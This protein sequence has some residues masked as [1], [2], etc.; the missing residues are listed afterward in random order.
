MKR[1]TGDLNN[2]MFEMSGKGNI[3]NGKMREVR[4]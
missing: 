2:A 4:K 3:R 1:K